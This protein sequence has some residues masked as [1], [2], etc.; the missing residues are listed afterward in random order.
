[1]SYWKDPAHIRTLLLYLLASAAVCAVCFYT[2]PEWG[3]IVAVVCGMFTVLRL[4]SDVVHDARVR[5][6]NRRVEAALRGEYKPSVSDEKR[7]ALYELDGNVYKLAIRLSDTQ[8]TLAQERAQSDRLLHGLARQLITR[9]E[10]LPAN[11]HRRELIALA[12]DM[13]NLAS[14]RGE[15]I[16][17]EQIEP[18]PAADVWRDAMTI[19]EETLRLKQVTVHAEIAPRAYVSTCPRSLVVGGLRG[20]LESCA[21]H[22]DV[23]AVLDCTVKQ[24]PVFTEFRITCDRL[25]WSAEQVAEIF[26]GTD[27]AEPALVYLSRLASLYRG[28][29]RAERQEGQTCH[30]IFRLYQ[31]DR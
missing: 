3:V 12:H 27:A 10:E 6:V 14:L 13:E 16:P 1:M 19:A 11:V 5:A 30:M 23:G 2:D 15:P 9:A 29:V 28:E 4:V 7:G 20:L 22:A 8:K 24:T 31:A 18:A 21:R 26:R 25:D 17:P